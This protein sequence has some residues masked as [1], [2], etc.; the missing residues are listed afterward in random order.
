MTLLIE[1]GGESIAGAVYDPMLDEL[2]SAEKGGGA[3]STVN[4][5]CAAKKATSRTCRRGG[6]PVPGQVKSLSVWTSIIPR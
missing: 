1:E 3:F 6:L 4:G 2:F 5:W